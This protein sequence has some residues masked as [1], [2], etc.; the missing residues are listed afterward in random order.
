VRPSAA[1]RERSRSQKGSNGSTAARRWHL[2]ARRVYIISELSEAKGRMSVW[3][4][5][6]SMCSSANP[7][8]ARAP[9]L[10][11][12]RAGALARF[13]GP[14]ATRRAVSSLPRKASLLDGPAPIA[15]ANVFAATPAAHGIL[16][17]LPAPAIHAQS[18]A[19]RRLITLGFGVTLWRIFNGKNQF[20]PSTEREALHRARRLCRAV[21]PALAPDAEQINQPSPVP[22]TVYPARAKVQGEF[23][24]GSRGALYSQRSPTRERGT[25]PLAPARSHTDAAE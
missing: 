3:S 4:R 25:R 23:W 8:P 22:E 21:N 18:S 24:P 7:K 11:A 15:L 13:G 10:Q 5:R 2:P 1:W 19:E 20:D 14:T 6:P 9:F 16:R 17:R 12:G